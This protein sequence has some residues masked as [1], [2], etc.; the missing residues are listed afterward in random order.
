M[1]AESLS[2]VVDG[3]WPVVYSKALL[4]NL[5]ILVPWMAQGKSVLLVGPEGCGK[6]VLV[7][8]AVERLRTK[9]KV[10]LCVIHCNAK[11]TSRDLLFKL[12]QLCL[13]GSCATGRILRPK[14]CQR[15]VVVLKELNLPQPDKY[16]TCELT[17]FLTSLFSHKSFYDESLE[18]VA[19]A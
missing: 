19:I 2:K 13:K 14:G 9:E 11:T 16:S 1:R 7:E 15:L 8:A 5:S 10:E 18:S 4:G 17:A 12:R 3:N 6:Q